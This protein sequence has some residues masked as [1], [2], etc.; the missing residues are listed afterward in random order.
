VHPSPLFAEPAKDNSAIALAP[1]DK[2]LVTVFGQPEISGELYVD[3][4]GNIALPFIG[5]LEV[6]N[7][8]VLECQKLIRDRLADGLLN[9]P[10]VSV[11]I[12]ELRPV[13]VL[14]DVRTPGVYPFR[15]GSTV[16]SA[17]AAA[18]GFGL[19][20]AL[21]NDALSEFIL[22]NERVRLL[23][24]QRQA[25]LVRQA[26]IEA[27]LDEKKLFTPPTPS[28]PQEGI[29]TAEIVAQEKQAFDAEAA[30]LQN[31]L[32]LLRAQKP[33][34]QALIDAHTAQIATAKR[35]LELVTQHSEE[36]SRMVKQGLGVS[37]VEMQLKLNQANQESELWRLTAEVS[38][39]Q[40]DMGELDVKLQD[41]VATFKQRLVT[42]LREVR[43]K[44][45]DIDV[46]L[47]SAQELRRVKMQ[48]AGS[49]EDS[50]VARN[51][52]VT[53]T[54]NGEVTVLQTTQTA[55]IEPGDVID[56]KKLP[57]PEMPGR[58]P[59][60]SLGQSGSQMDAVKAASK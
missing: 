42:E 47:P 6:K 4:A 60:A 52:T 59:S 36:Y 15:Y 20:G 24:F 8:T 21:Q 5:S 35:E 16:K 11:R 18:G 39:L 37:N 26:R 29:D 1:G 14:G 49:I 28:G 2:I 17:V 57:P 51:I 31:Q 55:L 53:R 13:A 33:R 50:E 58:T 48:R 23:T 9:Q 30:I 22:A 45:R 54:R 10:S 44:L 46:T 40:M 7:L 34:I 12:S 25:L 43:E 56:V 19:D 38:R 27:Q 32:G 3:G 41:A